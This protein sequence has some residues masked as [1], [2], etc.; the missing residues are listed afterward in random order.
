MMIEEKVYDRKKLLISV[1]CGVFPFVY[2][3]LYPKIFDYN[4]SVPS[5]YLG[6]LVSICNFY[7][8][9]WAWSRIFLKKRIALAISVIAVSYTHL[10]LQTKA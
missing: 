8:I 5:L 1:I 4:V 2:L 7:L 9:L 6:L 3:M 10:T